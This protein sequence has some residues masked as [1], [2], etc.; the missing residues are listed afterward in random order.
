MKLSA[1]FLFIRCMAN[2]IIE[3]R[4]VVNYLVPEGKVAE[5]MMNKMAAFLYLFME[6]VKKP[7]ECARPLHKLSG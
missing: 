1:K 3:R 5:A 7:L 2:W 6:H 4:S